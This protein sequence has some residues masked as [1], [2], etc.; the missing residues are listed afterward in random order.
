MHW[1]ES[2][3]APD[4]RWTISPL[5]LG[6]FFLLLCGWDF[7]P[8]PPASCLHR[9]MVGMGLLALSDNMFDSPLGLYWPHPSGFTLTTSGW[10][11]GP[12]SP[13]HSSRIPWEGEH[14][15][16]A[17]GDE[18]FICYLI[19]SDTTM[20]GGS[21]PLFKRLEAK[22]PTWHFNYHRVFYHNFSVSLA[23]VKL[24]LCKKFL[25]KV[26]L[27]MDL[28]LEW[29]LLRYFLSAL[30]GSSNLAAPSAPRPGYMKQKKTDS[31]FLDSLDSKFTSQS[32][33]STPFRF[34]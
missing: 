23:V 34:F 1:R 27:F 11:G 21:V 30:F 20:V 3:E 28:W 17:R 15:S 22:A 32:S 24:I 2:R 12:G 19:F 25:S 31:K 16:L 7:Q 5:S 29:V 26:V 33:F 14:S 4:Y 6:V 8:P 13:L 10:C 9:Y 18:C